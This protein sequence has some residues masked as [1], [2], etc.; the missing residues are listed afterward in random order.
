MDLSKYLVIGSYSEIRLW[1]ASWNH[2]CRS[3]K[4][5]FPGGITNLQVKFVIYVC[6]F[7]KTVISK[8]EFSQNETPEV[9]RMYDVTSRKKYES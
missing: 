7:C 5:T 1:N 4:N 6:S 3:M 2:K 8:L 9:T